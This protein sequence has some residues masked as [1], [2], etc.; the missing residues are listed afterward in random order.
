MRVLFMGTPDFSVGSFKALY[1]N[2]EIIGAVTQ[3]DKPQG[4]GYKLTASPIKRIAS[5]YSIPVY[6]PESLKNGAFSDVLQSLNPDII[7]V[8]AYGKILPK[9]VLDYPKYGCINLHGSLLPKYRGAAPMQRAIIDGEKITGVT[10]MFMAEGLDTGDML[11]KAEIKIEENDNFETVHDKLSE[12]GA[13]LLVSTLRKIEASQIKAIKQDENLATYAKKIE[14][15]DRLID[16]SKD[17][18]NIH[19]LIRG[20]SPIP[21]AFT[22][23]GEKLVKISDAQ[24]AE[25]NSINSN[26]GEVLSFDHGKIVVACGRGSISLNVLIPEGK[27]SMSAS[28]FIN[29]RQIKIGEVFGRK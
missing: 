4:R 27:K 1:D 19:N 7:V 21:L 8:V 6:Q 12:V 18:E 5:E 25:K 9:Y 24:I 14:K 15:E 13:S 3:P 2:F 17:A 22:Y 16:F 23:L 10:T 29:G 26:P 11:E 20:L 28:D